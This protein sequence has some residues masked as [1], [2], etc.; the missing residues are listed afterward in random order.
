M[1]FLT[2]FPLIMQQTK[3]LV[4][5]NFILTMRN[6]RIAL[7]QITIPFIFM[8]M[9]YGMRKSSTFLSNLPGLGN[10]VRDPKRITDFAI[11]PCEDKLLIRNPC[12]DFAWSGSGNPRIEGIV[13][14]IMEAN[15]GRPIPPDKVKSFRTKE[16]LN[17][18]LVKNPLTT[19]GA[20]HFRQTKKLK[21]SY[22]VVTNT[23]SYLKIGQIVEDYA[24]MH[25]LPLQLAATRE[26]A[27]SLLK[28]NKLILF[29]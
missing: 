9:L 11:P 29:L 14:R 22:G 5:K 10:A 8:G 27:R 23:S 1:D 4:R 3:T 7:I 26:I 18:W 6:K 13:K 19:P 20:L 24:F 17:E 15:P 16:E 12:Y 25:Q 2:G 21:L 28:G